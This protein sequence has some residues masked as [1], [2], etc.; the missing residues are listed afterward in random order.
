MSWFFLGGGIFLLL[1]GVVL[2]FIVLNKKD[3]SSKEKG[4]VDIYN[5]SPRKNQNNPHYRRNS[6][7]ESGRK[8]GSGGVDRTV[9]SRYK[10]QSSSKGE[11]HQ[12][13]RLR[14]NK[15]Q[16]AR[17]NDE[18]EEL[19][20][21]INRREKILKEKVQGIDLDKLQE[22]RRS[23][24]NRTLDQ[25]YRHLEKEMLPDHYLKAVKLFEQGEGI[26]GIAE[27]MNMGIRETELIVKMHVD[28]VD[29]YAG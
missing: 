3:N 6:S 14:D 16:L 1:L 18:L 19:I 20:S 2:R 9:A 5:R 22:H 10:A 8:R 12:N 13:S 4:A 11:A 23:N 21:E 25:Q 15:R 28:G 17:I 27:K 26:E 29:D 24:F 7:P